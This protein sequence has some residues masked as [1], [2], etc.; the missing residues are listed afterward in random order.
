MSNIIIS[1]IS[2]WG[3]I[4]NYIKIESSSLSNG[5]GWRVVLWCAGC[6]NHCEGCHNPETWDPNAGKPFT[7]KEL[8]LLCKLLVYPYIQG[9]TITGGDPLFPGNREEVG[10]ITKTIKELFPTKDIWLYTGYK[11]EDVKDL[12]AF[13]YTDVCVDGRFVQELRDVSLAFRGSSNQR[14]IDVQNSKDE[15]KVLDLD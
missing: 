11:Y 5:V 1:T 9:I 15:V 7:E 12:E 13:K 10:K 8:H 3:V 14:I 6:E 2:N 4:M